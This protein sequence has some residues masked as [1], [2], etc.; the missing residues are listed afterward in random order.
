MNGSGIVEFRTSGSTGGAKTIVKQVAQLEADVEMLAGTFS[1]IFSLRPYFLTTIRPEHMFG[2]LWR[3]MLPG[4][5]GCEVHPGTVVSVEELAAAAE[6]RGRTVLVTTPSFLEQAVKREEF[7]L[8][9]PSLAGIVTS[10]SLLKRDLSQKVL[11]LTGVSPTEIFGSTET[12]S[13]AWRRQ[14]EGEEWTLFEG[15]EAERTDDGRIKVDSAFSISR[16]FVMGDFVEFVSPRRFLLKGR[17][18]RNV[19]ILEKY[20]SLPALEAAMEAHPFVAKAHA[21]ASDEPVPRVRALAELT[22]EGKNELKRSGYAGMT[23]LLKREIAGIEAF[24]FPRRIRYLNAFPYNEQGK[25]VKAAVAPILASRYQEPVSENESA[26]ADNYGADLTFIRDA[27]YFDGHFKTFKILPGV[28][29]LDYA[30]RCIRRQWQTGAF[31]GSVSKLKFQRPVL[32]GET[33]RIE[34]GKKD[35]LTFAFTIKSGETVCTSGIFNWKGA[36]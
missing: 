30:V 17:A 22:L 21:I 33:V 34:I 20:V 18:D 36:R 2:T 16:P 32:P 24:A 27:V 8:L 9:K 13:V 5:I 26:S 19:K 28:V 7:A 11:E 14:A 25:L 3:Q 31:S 4:R 29:Q 12:G 1:D 10:G 35:E 23:A 6:G 15:V